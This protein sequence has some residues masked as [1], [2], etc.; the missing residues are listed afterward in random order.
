M[1]RTS[2]DITGSEKLL[3]QQLDA[4]PD[5]G[6]SEALA[7]VSGQIVNKTITGG[8]GSPGGSDT[9]VQFN[10]GG[11]FGGEAGMTYNKTTDTL[12]VAGDVLADRIALED[13]NSSHRLYIDPGTDLSADRT[14]TLTTGDASR[15]LTMAGDATISGTNTGDQTI[16]LSGDVTGTGTGAITATIA[17]DAVTYAKIQNVS[18][19][20]KILGRSSVGAGDIEEI[21]CTAAGRA[22]LDDVDASAQRTTLGLG[23]LATQNGTFSGTSSGTNTGDQTITNTSDATSHTVTLSASGGSV[24]LIEGTNITLT[25]GGTGSAGTVTIA[26]SGGSGDVTAAASLTDEAIVRGDGG[27]KGVQTS[28]VTISDTNVVSGAT[29]LNVDNLRL[30]G[31][32]LSS[33][34]TNGNINLTPNGTGEVVSGILRASGSAGVVLKNNAGTAQAEFGAGGG[35]NATINGTTNIAAAS[36]DYHQI[37]GGTGTITDT[38]TGSSTDINI[39]LVP[40]GTGRLQAG[41][42]NVPTISSTDTL[43]NKTLTSPTLTTPVLGTPSSGTLT[44]CTGLPVAGG[45]TGAATFTDGG[46]IIGNGT[47]ALQVTS[48]GTAGQVLTSN[49]AGVDPTFQTPSSFGVPLNLSISSYETS[50]VYTDDVAYIATV[51]AGD[52]TAYCNGT[53]TSL[54]RYNGTTLQSIS[55][56]TIWASTTTNCGVVIIGGYVYFHLINSTTERRIY[57]AATT[58]NIASSGNWTQL[59][60]SGANFAAATG[61]NLQMIGYGNGAFWFADATN[62]VYMYATLSGTTLTQQG[63]ITVTGSD[64]NL[65]SAVNNNGVFASFNSAPFI[66]MANFSGTLQTDRTVNNASNARPINV[67]DYLYILTASNTYTRVDL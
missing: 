22:L 6:A 66:R 67:E 39:N 14:L 18:A 10:D 46:V 52:L 55:S 17:N 40:K 4:L 8:S 42:V 29:Q 31:N 36:A 60:L 49:G 24:Q 64:Y 27:V 45:G 43:T 34:D 50:T 25:T 59:T 30:D 61:F 3:L 32:T 26:A 20:D 58:T 56:T 1:A 57:R 7:K 38:A 13:T 35:T 23:T 16:T 33:T 62:G 11:S 41:G 65:G 19:T 54:R 21:D 53:N 51:S 2:N 48:A 44:N 5:S 63:T 28:G 47:G 9:Q 37:A 12:T 15:T